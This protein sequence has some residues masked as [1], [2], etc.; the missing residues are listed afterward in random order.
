MAGVTFAAKLRDDGSLPMPKEAADELGLHPG[1]EVQVRVEPRSGAAHT[2]EPDQV[3]LQ[4][5]FERFFDQLDTLTFEEPTTQ[6]AGDPAEAA[7][8]EAMDDKYRKLGFES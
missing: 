7:F 8:A 2:G 6:P 5:R 4:A 3:T 1:D